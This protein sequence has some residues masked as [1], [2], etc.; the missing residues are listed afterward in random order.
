MPDQALASVSTDVA[1]AVRR[2]VQVALPQAGDVDP[3]VRASTHADLQANVALPLAKRLRQPPAV[4]AAQIAEHLGDPLVDGAEVSG[5]GFINITIAAA[6]LWRRA[7]VRLNDPR[8]GVSQPRRGERTVIDYSSPNIAKDMHVG[9]LR[10]TV[11]GDCLVRLLSHLGADVI[12]QNHLGDWGTQFGMLIQYIEENPEQ[13]WRAGELAASGITDSSTS[14]L[15][16]LYRA[17]RLTFDADPGFADRSRARV[18]K[19]QSGDEQTLRMWRE[20]VAESQGAFQAI[21]AR[22]GILLTP[23]DS[24]GE[25]FYNPWLADVADEL[26]ADGIAVES[27]GALCVFDDEVL[28]P[29][30]EPVPLIVRKSGGGYGYDA[31]DLATIRYRMRDL[32]AD[33]VLYVVD[34]RQSMHFRLIF[35]CA[36]RAGWITGDADV[37]HLAFGTVLGPDGRPFKTRA[38]GTVPLSDLLDDAVRQARLIVAEK[39]PGL[40]VAGLDA[41]AEIVGIASVKYAELSTSRVKD[42]VFDVNRMVSFTG[43]TGAYLQY[44]H[45][46]VNSILRRAATAG[47]APELRISDEIEPQERAVILA[48]DAFGDCLAEVAETLEP[49]RLCGYLYDLCKVF[50]DFYEACPVIKADSEQK[51]GNRLALC[52]LTGNT[53]QTGLHLLG[54]TAPERL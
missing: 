13:L 27:Q 30:G 42:Y 20:I 28:G 51:R 17:A 34:A 21:Y 54:I 41:L 33:R 26:V 24:A 38:G 8:L 53:I 47:A 43:D 45:A 48:L 16:G 19:L 10:T 3:L 18:V 44:A 49:H 7:A 6:E 32:K 35:D 37:R 25:S 52:Q 4:L 22:L 15:D 1:G 31:T 29:D 46:R 5:P 39:Q 12:R 50:T 36:R 40:P 9:H 2:A 23:A 11:I 14:A